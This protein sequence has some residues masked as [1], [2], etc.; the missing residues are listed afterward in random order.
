MPLENLI[1][2]LVF[3]G[4]LVSTPGP[5]NML[6]LAAGARD[7]VRR[8]LPLL[9]GTIFGKTFV[10]LGLAA[11]LW[12]VIDKFPSVLSA[13]KIAGAVYVLWLA[14]QIL[15]IKIQGQ[16]DAS[17]IG[18]W[19]GLLVHP[20]NPKAWA[21]VVSAYGQFIDARGDWWTQVFVVWLAFFGWQCLAQTFWCW[22]GA[23]AAQFLSGARA[24]KFLMRF[25]AALMVGAVLWALIN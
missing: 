16:T 7:G 21:M 15:R 6:M 18:F 20:L 22:C 24:E 5:A 2:L 14:R 1:P 17:R 23:R 10:H 8:S 12:G 4:V 19:R 11:G 13:M 25:L 3:A 9:A